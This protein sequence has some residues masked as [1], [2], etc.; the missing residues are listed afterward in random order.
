MTGK[1]TGPKRKGIVC[2]GETEKEN[3]SQQDTYGSHRE[4]AHLK[5]VIQTGVIHRVYLCISPASDFPPSN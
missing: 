5:Q 4:G 3:A 2:G 1:G